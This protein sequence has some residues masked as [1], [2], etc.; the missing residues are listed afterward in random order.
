MKM[1]I[2]QKERRVERI[3]EYWERKGRRKSLGEQ[4]KKIKKKDWKKQRCEK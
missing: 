4:K 3:D 1:E 2:L